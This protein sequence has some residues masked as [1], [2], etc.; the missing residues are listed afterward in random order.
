MA[1]SLSG[2]LC[3]MVRPTRRTTRRAFT[4]SDTAA[5]APSSSSG[6]IRAGG[7][8]VVSLRPRRRTMR[9]RP[10]GRRPPGPPRPRPPGT[11]G[12]SSSAGQ[13]PLQLGL[14]RHP[15][16]PCPLHHAHLAV[17]L[18]DHDGDGVRVLGDPQG[19][20]V[21][22]PEALRE[23]HLGEREGGRRRPAPK[24]PRMMTA[25]SWSSVRGMKIVH[26]QLVRQ[27]GVDHHAGLGDLL[28]AGLALQHDQG[29]VAVARQHAG[30]LGD[31]V[32]HVL[33]AALGRGGEQPADGAHP[34]DPLQ[35]A[36]Q[37]RLEDHHQREQAHDGAGL[38]DLGEQA[39][40]QELGEGVDAEQDGDA[41]DE[42]DG[43]GAADQ[44]EHPVDEQRRDRRCRGRSP[45]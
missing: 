19:G 10:P 25:P 16:D 2:Q 21:T 15:D 22:R 41:D 8:G 32:G 7:A 33:D 30:G 4:R 42:G 36:A 17:L 3:T 34:A 26:R 39:E 20:A 43:A 45:A 18:G 23:R 35:R 28:E 27:V 5:A 40:L 31:L 29:A 1:A 11:V 12:A 14:G 9:S 13:G 24:S 37:L 6:S 38:E 44:A